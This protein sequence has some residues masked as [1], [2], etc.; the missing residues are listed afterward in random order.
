MKDIPDSIY[1]TRLS[2]DRFAMRHMGLAKELVD[3]AIT[4]W[5]IE[6]CHRTKIPQ[7]LMMRVMRYLV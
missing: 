1:F 5:T 6:G 2:W 7:D 3:R 4:E